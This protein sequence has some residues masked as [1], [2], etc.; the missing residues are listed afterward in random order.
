MEAWR[1]TDLLHG[2]TMKGQTVGV[3]GPPAW[4]GVGLG[5]GALLLGCRLFGLEF[6]PPGMAKHPALTAI[7]ALD[8]QME[9]DRTPS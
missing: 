4:Y 1:R 7:P 3:S 2:I 5:V 9:E 6:W 8:L